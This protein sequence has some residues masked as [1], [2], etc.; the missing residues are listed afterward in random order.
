MLTSPHLTSEGVK[1]RM[2]PDLRTLKLSPQS[3]NCFVAAARLRTGYRDHLSIVGDT[4]AMA[5]APY[6][7]Y[8]QCLLALEN[9]Q[10]IL[11]TLFAAHSHDC[12]PQFRYNTVMTV[13]ANLETKQST[14]ATPI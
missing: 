14:L 12:G 7:K 6:L 1:G 11:R 4:R 5:M 3:V 9:L 2:R 13:C 8:S 10:V